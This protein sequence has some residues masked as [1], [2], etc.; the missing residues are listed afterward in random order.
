MASIPSG[1]STISTEERTGTN[2]M[3]TFVALLLLAAANAEDK[4]IGGSAVTSTAD[5]PWQVSLQQSGCHFC[6]GTVI[7]PTHVM[8]AGHCKINGFL[9]RYTVALGGIDY[10][11][12]D[13]QL[14]MSSWVV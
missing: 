7:S 3:Y 10:T 8:S 12:L 5:A 11:N 13:Q 14:S 2:K 1:S 4:I 9:S 6:G